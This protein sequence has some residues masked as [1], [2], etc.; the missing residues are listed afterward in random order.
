MLKVLNLSVTSS[1]HENNRKLSISLIVTKRNP[2]LVFIIRLQF[3]RTGA[4]HLLILFIEFTSVSLKILSSLSDHFEIVSD[5]L[6]TSVRS[7]F[8]FTAVISNRFF[9]NDSERKISWTN[10]RIFDF[11]WV[12]SVVS[13]HVS[14]FLTPWSWFVTK[15]SREIF[16][17]Q[18]ASLCSC[19]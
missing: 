1:R 10:G 15:P 11:L 13:D 17:V 8:V 5:A 7:S 16:V 19:V 18:E 3:F 4:L 12:R 6:P 9:F 14:S 2:F